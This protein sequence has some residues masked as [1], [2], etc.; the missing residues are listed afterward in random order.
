MQLGSD[1]LLFVLV[2]SVVRK[3]TEEV[4]EQQR[5]AETVGGLHQLQPVLLQVSSGEQ[6]SAVRSSG[7]SKMRCWPSHRVYPPPRLN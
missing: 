4:Q 3:L 6:H 5:L 1:S 7:S 2:E